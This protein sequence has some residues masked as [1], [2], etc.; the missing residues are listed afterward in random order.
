MNAKLIGPTVAGR[1]RKVFVQRS[2][3]GTMELAD[4]RFQETQLT[5]ITIQ[6]GSMDDV[7]PTVPLIEAAYEPYHPKKDVEKTVP[8]DLLLQAQKS[9]RQFTIILGTIAAI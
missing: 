4:L 7:L 9:A 5:Q 1:S 3:R 2:H 6:V 8:Y